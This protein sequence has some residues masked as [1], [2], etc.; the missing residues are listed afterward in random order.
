MFPEL[1]LISM[2]KPPHKTPQVTTE[3]S[4]PWA[5]YNKLP[6]EIQAP[7]P[8]PVSLGPETHNVVDFRKVICMCAQ[9]FTIAIGT[10]SQAGH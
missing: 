9:A 7:I 8:Y 1:H 5:R 10:W 2:I 6:D 3:V 4:R